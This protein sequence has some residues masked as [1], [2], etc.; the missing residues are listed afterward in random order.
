MPESQFMICAQSLVR[1][2]VA[3]VASLAEELIG[4][5]M[6]YLAISRDNLAN[7]LHGLAYNR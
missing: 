6:W 3:T 5:R 2:C 7:C 1:A 4:I